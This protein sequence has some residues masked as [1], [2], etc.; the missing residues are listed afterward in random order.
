MKAFGKA[1]PPL[2]KKLDKLKAMKNAVQELNKEVSEQEQSVTA[3]EELQQQ[4]SKVT[5]LMDTPHTC[6]RTFCVVADAGGQVHIY[7]KEGP[8]E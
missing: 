4:K 5:Q 6:K 7:V 2:A 3:A 8:R 1:P